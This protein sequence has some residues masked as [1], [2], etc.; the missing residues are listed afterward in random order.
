MLI[1]L[2]NQHIF[3]FVIDYICLTLHYY[4]ISGKSYHDREGKWG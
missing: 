3:A 4:L 1:F 2:P